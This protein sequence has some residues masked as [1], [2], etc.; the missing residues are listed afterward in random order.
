MD[1]SLLVKLFG[2]RGALLNGDPLVY[3]RWRWLK[4][5]LPTTRNGEKLI[6]IG[7]GSGAFTIAASLRGYDAVGLS[8]DSRNQGIAAA[9]ADLCRCKHAVF[10]TEDVRLLG[11]RPE[12]V[13]RYD[14]AICLETIEHVIDDRKLIRNIY[15]CLRP[16][17]LLLVTTPNYFYRAI[18]PGD[19]GPFSVF[20]DGWHV[21]RGYTSAMLRELCDDA[22][23]AIEEVSSCSG[24]ISQKIT[25]LM[26][27]SP[28]IMGWVVTF[29]L[30]IF[31]PIADWLVTK[32][33]GWPDFSICLVAY[34]PR[35][36]G[37]SRPA[38]WS[39]D[40]QST[41]VYP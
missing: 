35:V 9:R 5:H 23:F 13:G 7:C 40:R 16:G 10:L 39:A 22:G 29:P 4:R 6:D 1:R 11:E 33:T 36:D 34:K 24:F 17:G 38:R 15:A 20:E 2:Y 18:S 37:K 30:R 14:V 21:R 3:D 41:S 12:H 27:V 8:W 31:P 32:L 25:W 28:W 26:R 19:D